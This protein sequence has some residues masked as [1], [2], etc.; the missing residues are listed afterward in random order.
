VI[1]FGI[2]GTGAMA[3]Q[4]ARTIALS[5]CARIVRVASRSTSRGTRFAKQHKIAAWGDEAALLADPAADAVYVAGR[6]GE[7]AAASLAALHAGKAVLC[8]KPFACSPEEAMA[9]IE[10]AQ[11][12]GRLFMEA[13]ATPFLPAVAEAIARATSGEFGA[14]Q[15]LAASFGYKVDRHSHRGLFAEDG[16]VLLDRA[17]Y[18]LTL[19]LLAL[20]P[21]IDSEIDGDLY[22]DRN[23]LDVAVHIQLSHQSGARSDLTAS[24]VERLPNSLSI[25]CE[26]AQIRV[27][28]PLLAGRRVTIGPPLQDLSAAIADRPFAQ[29]PVVRRA[30][31]LLARLTGSWRPYGA[32]PYLPELE[33]FCALLR[34]GHIES[35]ILT[36]RLMLEVQHIIGR[37]RSPK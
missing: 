24:L 23:G 6:N 3:H 21:V 28:A 10:T 9:V 1:G 14:P 30:G 32:S 27:D 22:T 31:D 33:H 15:H 13:M 5:K 19:A 20:G 8:E 25:G 35:P 17:V 36:H 26:H 18:P 2:I 4:M 29:N 16:G 7:H 37:V 12:A 34:G 11:T